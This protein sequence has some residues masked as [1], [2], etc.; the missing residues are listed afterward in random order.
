MQCIYINLDEA[1]ARREAV[2]R[3]FRE[4]C[5]ASWTLERL[6]AFDRAYVEQAKIPG[7]LSAGEKACFLSH[8]RA[9]E[10][11][12]ESDGPVLIAEDDVELGPAT[13]GVL[14]DV[15]RR[16]PPEAWDLLYTE[17][18]VWGIGVHRM[19]DLWTLHQ[20][21][22][23]QRQFKI[24]N[25]RTIPFAGATC[26]VVNERSKQKVVDALRTHSPLRTP[27]DL[28]LQHLILRRE[29]HG[30][31]VYPFV[32][33]ISAESSCSQIQTPDASD[34]RMLRTAVRRGMWVGCDRAAVEQAIDAIDL[35]SY[36][37]QTLFQAKILRSIALEML[38]GLIMESADRERDHSA[39]EAAIGAGPDGSSSLK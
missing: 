37:P 16:L 14:D 22:T 19:I 5:P 24:V 35:G 9:L 28:L 1:E 39:G 29:L 2:E 18:D 8:L 20:L 12:M 27:V 13:A 7:T 6:P 36:D 10:S 23:I 15:I 21:L 17:V 38:S 31:V 4:N 30:S 11:S 32:T 3:T 33:S 34:G 25:L 26:Y